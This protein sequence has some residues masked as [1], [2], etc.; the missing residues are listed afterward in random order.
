M[1][2]Q[3]LAEHPHWKVGGEIDLS[4]P[5]P[6]TTEDG[7]AA[8]HGCA[9]GD[10]APRLYLVPQ[11]TPF[12]DIIDFFEIGSHS[13]PCHGWDECELRDLVAT[14]LR[15]IHEIVPGSIEV[16]TPS[17]LRFRFWRCLRNDEL[18][19]IEAV[20]G[21]ADEYQAGLDRYINHGLSGSSLLH[22]VGTT[23]VLYL[24]WR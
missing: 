5:L 14:C 21:K 1:H 19:E 17:E 24:C 10:W 22:D 3:P 9:P 20:Y 6:D 11:E 23:G 7:M 16:A 12:E 13:S 8:I 18:E 15:T 4:D 2:L